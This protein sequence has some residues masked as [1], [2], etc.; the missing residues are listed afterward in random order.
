MEWTVRFIN[1]A[2]G[3]IQSIVMVLPPS[4]AIA[5]PILILSLIALAVKR[6]FF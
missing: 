1:N 5:L 4:M 6:I 3:F 2:I